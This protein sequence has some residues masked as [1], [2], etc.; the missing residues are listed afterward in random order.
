MFQRE[1]GLQ[2]ALAAFK[3]ELGEFMKEMVCHELCCGGWSHCPAGPLCAPILTGTVGS[4]R[5]GKLVS[6]I[7]GRV[8][9]SSRL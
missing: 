9:S 5:G 4:L 3:M 1:L 6:S 2:K 7:T 8:D